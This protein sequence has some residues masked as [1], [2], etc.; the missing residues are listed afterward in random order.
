MIIIRLIL[1]CVIVYL[2]VRSLIGYLKD[3]TPAARSDASDKKDKV[4]NKKIS[5]QIGEYIDYEE[6]DD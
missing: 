1:I 5:K 4:V 2:I 3:E 6:V